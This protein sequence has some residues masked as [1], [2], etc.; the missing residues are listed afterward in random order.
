M[1]RI[2]LFPTRRQF[3]QLSA[4]AAGVTVLPSCGG[5]KK[6]AL[7]SANER[8]ALV[9]LAEWLVP[10][11]Q[12][13]SGAELGAIEYLEGMLT[14]FDE[15]PPRLFAGGPFS[16]RTDFADGTTPPN[17]FEEFLTIDRI[18]RTAWKL[19]ILGS[20]A[21]PGGAPNDELLG[22][23]IGLKKRIQRGIAEV[24]A[25]A[26]APLETLDDAAVTEVWNDARSDFRETF[27]AAV[28]EGCFAPPEYGGNKNGAGWT[29]CHF[30]GDSQPLGYSIWDETLGAYRER[31]EAPNS[32]ANPGTDP[33]PL[34]DE[35]RA[36]VAQVVAF[37][38]GMAF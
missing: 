17:D 33:D 29:I 15:N 23:R 18:T 8:R 5:S 24:V 37:L 2:R 38:G 32:T 30:E 28:I 21:I 3:L 12:D 13:P 27:Q 20:D 14:M 6:S 9:R 31:P 1:R 19:A 4:A 26:P 25:D 10:A 16:G 11:D 7:F 34:D 22:K 36:L 35:T